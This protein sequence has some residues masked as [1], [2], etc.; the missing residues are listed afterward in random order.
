MKLSLLARSATS[1]LLA[2]TMLVS[3]LARA[4]DEVDFGG[5]FLVEE[6]ANAEELSA[7]QSV[8]E[9]KHVKARELAEKIVTHEPKSFVGHFVLGYVQHYAEANFPKAVYHQ[10]LARRHFEERFGDQ[11]TPDKPWKWHARILRELSA[12]QGDLENY[13]ERLRLIEVYNALYQP[14]M[15]AERAWPLMKL[16]RY[17]EARLAAREGLGSDDPRQVEI[18]LNALCAIEFE[19]G[20]DGASYEACRRAMDH[21]RERGGANAVDLTNFAEAARSVFELDEA[22][23]ILLEATRAE[24]AWYGNP[25]MELGELYTRQGRF[26]EALEALKRVPQ[27]RASRPPHVRDA[28][29]NEARR[30]LSAFFVVVGRPDDAIRI[31]EKAL[32]LPDRRAHNSRDPAQ[33]RAIVALLDRRARLSAAERI[34]EEASAKSLPHR[35]WAYA[36]ASWLRFG[37]FLSG[38][39]AAKLLSDERKLV[40]TFRIG[41]AESA[42]MP[43]WLAGELV[44]VTGSAVA[45]SALSR[46]R[47]REKRPGALAY[48]E[49]FEAEAEL[50]AGRASRAVELCRKAL[51]SIGRSESLLRARC[52][53]IAAEGERRMGRLDRAAAHYDAAFQNDPGVLRRF[54]L[55]LPVRLS[56]RGDS[57]AE[58]VAAALSRSP[59]F[60]AGDH[61]LLLAIE[62]TAAGGKVCLVGA[63]GNVLGCGEATPESHDDAER[64]AERI[65]ADVHD[66][67][68]APRI[69]LSQADANGLDGSN[70][71]SRDP[72]RTLF[73]TAVPSDAEP[74][75]ELESD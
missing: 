49:A 15:L 37:G 8:V 71:V 73:D 7:F 46:A 43:P 61:G 65:V 62:A 3:A 29:R 41:T 28:D 5:L 12:A 2:T 68:F 57:V 60:D 58:A 45:S 10:E 18:A 55:A 54:G 64:L 24:V 69:D 17:D 21:A 4:D 32:V 30:A 52:E 23:R 27:Y 48:Y 25:W 34:L 9:G 13:A 22:E 14:H 70:R 56:V 38:R 31:T 42:V 74:S 66:A 33:D 26:A 53:A 44:Q 67:M 39:Q 20:N 36:R 6:G 19:A 59:R 40:G 11:P 16:A 51:S 1:A 75:E 47:T 35:V 50:E 63:N 72:L